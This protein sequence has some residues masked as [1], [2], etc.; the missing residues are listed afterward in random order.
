M[1][2]LVN[3]KKKTLAPACL[4]SELIKLYSRKNPHVIA[5]VNGAIIKSDR[6]PETGL[7]N[8]DRVELVT[9]VGGG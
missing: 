7:K 5:E 1:H 9:F 3:G 2:I 4:L 8:G 6:W